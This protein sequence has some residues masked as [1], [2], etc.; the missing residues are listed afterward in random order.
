MRRYSGT[1]AKI[2]EAIAQDVACDVIARANPAGAD[3]LARRIVAAFQA[4]LAA[5]PPNIAVTFLASWNFNSPPS[6]EICMKPIP[7]WIG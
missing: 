3:E 6:L 5:A 7:G 2:S 4:A 1:P